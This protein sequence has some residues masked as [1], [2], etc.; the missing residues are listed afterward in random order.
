MEPS[1]PEH[2]ED[3]LDVE[4][5]ELAARSSR[6]PYPNPRLDSPYNSE[7]E[8]RVEE[9]LREVNECIRGTLEQH[10]SA[11]PATLN[12][13]EATV[14]PACNITPVSMIRANNK[15]QAELR[16]ITGDELKV[17]QTEG[18]SLDDN[19]F[20]C[21][22][23]DKTWADYDIVPEFIFKTWS[24]HFKTKFRK[25]KDKEME[26]ATSGGGQPSTQVKAS[27]TPQVSKPQGTTQTPKQ[28]KPEKGSKRVAEDHESSSGQ[29]SSNRV[30]R[31]KYV[32]A[33]L[34][35]ST[36]KPELKVTPGPDISVV[37][38]HFIVFINDNSTYTVSIGHMGRSSFEM[39]SIL[40]SA[41]GLANPKQAGEWYFHG[42]RYTAHAYNVVREMA[43]QGYAIT[44]VP[45]HPAVLWTSEKKVA[46]ERVDVWLTYAWPGQDQVREEV[47]AMLPPSAI[48]SHTGWVMSVTPLLQVQKFIC[49]Y[50]HLQFIN[51]LVADLCDTI[52][53]VP[54]HVAFWAVTKSMTREY[55]PLQRAIAL[56]TAIGT[57]PP[58]DLITRSNIA[59]IAQ[60][61]RTDQWSSPGASSSTDFQFTPRDDH[62]SERSG[63]ASARDQP[64]EQ[65]GAPLTTTHLIRY[66]LDEVSTVAD[67]MAW[68]M[69]KD[70]DMIKAERKITTL[71]DLFAIIAVIPKRAIS[72]VRLKKVM[73]TE[74][75]Q[76]RLD[77]IP[78]A[79]W[80][81]PH[82][83]D[84]ALELYENKQLMGQTE[85]ALKIFS[86]TLTGPQTR[87]FASYKARY[88]TEMEQTL[89]ITDASRVDQRDRIPGIIA[90]YETG[91]HLAIILTD[92]LGRSYARK[93][94][95]PIRY[96]MRD[97]SQRKQYNQSHK[98]GFDLDHS[99]DAT[100]ERIV[101]WRQC[102]EY[103]ASVKRIREVIAPNL[104][105]PD[106]SS[107][108][109]DRPTSE[110]GG[111]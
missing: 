100:A 20:F 24:K 70:V 64:R 60:P 71:D 29:A 46:R 57:L 14:H 63:R 19:H 91:V 66:N 78:Y 53:D 86:A 58:N 17:C 67:N 22:P 27:S 34:P 26:S 89:L 93:L 12:L 94:L 104:T 37:K 79:D 106:W 23:P 48:A 111:M 77:E 10:S 76:T 102:E 25:S 44:W 36:G 98:T 3:A 30:V 87:A 31:G 7:D 107:R 59:V 73:P 13:S 52:T 45:N 69:H 11:E 101:N 42:I 55:S 72:I 40:A 68:T 4:L 32:S 110:E 74:E 90:K 9:A 97:Y 81:H 5:G 49:K 105:I 15:Q 35:T 51:A 82:I 43:R 65:R 96:F 99:E 39:E 47:R 8:A 16:M 41:M 103:K 6:R 109:R 88:S 62:S 33:T 54:T 108:P 85:E 84:R 95:N 2:V 61:T 92:D 83:I 38:F 18:F 80:I 1:S 21:P 75:L 28:K 50:A 56:Q